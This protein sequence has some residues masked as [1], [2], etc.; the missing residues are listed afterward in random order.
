[1]YAILPFNFLYD[2][3]LSFPTIQATETTTTRT[4]AKAATAAT[5]TTTTN[6]DGN[7]SEPPPTQTQDLKAATEKKRSKKK[8]CWR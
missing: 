6:C 2:F 1:M 7:C 5:A 3:F 8:N 4:E